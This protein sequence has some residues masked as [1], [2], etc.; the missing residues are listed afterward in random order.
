M[1]KIL[2]I[3][4]ILMLVLVGCGGKEEVSVKVLSPAG[5]PALAQT[6][7]QS[8]N[9]SI[10]SNVTVE[11]E[12]V[13][14]AS[15]LGAAFTSESHDFIYAPI[16]MGVKMYNA[17][18]KYQLAATVVFGNN[19]IVTVTD[20]EFTFDDLNGVDV[21]L[22]GQGNV[23]AIVANTLFDYNEVTPSEIEYV[24]ATSDSVNQIILDNSK[25]CLIAEPSLSTLKT[26]L[27]STGVTNLKIID[28]QAEWKKM[29][30]NDSYPQAAIFVNKEFA[31]NN[32][33]IV[34]NYLDKV[35]DSVD[36]ANSNANEVAK[37]AV[38]LE[39]GFPEPVLVSA[40]PLSNL[41]FKNASE[42]KSSVEYLLNK[43]LESNG[44]LIGGKLPDDNFYFA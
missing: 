16:N 11:T 3:C 28:L 19:Y 43:I 41:L 14:D 29:T 44:S 36:Y 6:Q 40:I 1:K 31:A 26:K 12:I 4:L 34:K 30:G 37:M 38:E 21:T 13:S 24:A 32:N 33:K 25:I 27:A 10:G 35:S 23:P 18:S 8:T 9:P 17:S 2:S 22:F 7:F 39:Y 42:S 15:K 5:S 20:E